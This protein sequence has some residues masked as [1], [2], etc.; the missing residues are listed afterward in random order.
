EVRPKVVAFCPGNLPGYINLPLLA[1]RHLL[2]AAVLSRTLPAK[3]GPPVA[4]TFDSLY[5][6]ASATDLARLSSP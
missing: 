2:H 6:R 4:E 5:V 3:A 1:E